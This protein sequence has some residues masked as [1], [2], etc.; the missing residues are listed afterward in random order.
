MQGVRLQLHRQAEAWPQL[1]DDSVCRVA[2][3][4]RFI[5][6]AHCPTDWRIPRGGFEM[7]QGFCPQECAETGAAQ[8]RRRG[9]RAG[10]D[11]AFS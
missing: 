2:V 10:R 4:K 11:V 5:A 7:D 9:R 1:G 6:T 8:R 3:S